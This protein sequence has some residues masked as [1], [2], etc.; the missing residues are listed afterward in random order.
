[1]GLLLPQ[2]GD[3][4]RG[5]VADLAPF[6]Q[7]LASARAAAMQTKDFAEVD[8]LKAAFLAA[9]LEVRMAKDGVDLVPGPTFD[10]TKLEG[11]L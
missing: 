6:A 10:P 2:M 11:L 7:A 3:W 1:L 4:A 5:A 8:R 9:G